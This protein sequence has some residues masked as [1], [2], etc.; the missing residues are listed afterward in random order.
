MPRLTV[1]LTLRRVQRILFTF[2]YVRISHFMRHLEEAWPS[3]SKKKGLH[4][5]LRSASQ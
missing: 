4:D 5:V 2:T 1:V 3:P